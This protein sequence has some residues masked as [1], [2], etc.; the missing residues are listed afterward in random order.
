M[1]NVL[2][3]SH[4]DYSTAEFRGSRCDPSPRHIPTRTGPGTFHRNLGE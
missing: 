1:G 4:T 2:E 3:V